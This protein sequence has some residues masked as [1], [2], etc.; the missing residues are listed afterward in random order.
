[1]YQS[2][3]RNPTSL[4]QHHYSDGA[5]SSEDKASFDAHLVDTTNPHAT[6]KPKSVKETVTIPQTPNKPVTQHKPLPSD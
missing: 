2:L 3:P 1:M 4:W 6:Q 5:M